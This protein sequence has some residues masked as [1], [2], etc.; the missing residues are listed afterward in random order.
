MK[1][2]S[3]LILSTAIAIFSLQS[4]A[5]DNLCDVNIEKIDEALLTAGQN[6]GGGA[7]NNL[8]QT[9]KEAMEAKKAGDID[10]CVGLTQRAL[11]GAENTSMGAGGGN[12]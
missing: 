12:K 7:T 2:K 3:A 9:K 1:H 4:Y 6:L 8:K 10:K 5:A 11:V